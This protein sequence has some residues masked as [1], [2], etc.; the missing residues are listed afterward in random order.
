MNGAEHFQGVTALRIESH[1]VG[2]QLPHSFQ[3]LG[4]A[5]HKGP[6]AF[7][8]FVR[9]VYDNSNC[10]SAQ[11]PN[12][13]HNLLFFAIYFVVCGPGFTVSVLVGD[14]S[15]DAIAPEIG[16]WRA[17][18]KVC[19]PLLGFF[20][21]LF[22]ADNGFFGVKNFTANR[23]LAEVDIGID[24]GNYAAGA[25]NGL[26]H[27]FDALFQA[28]LDLLAMLKLGAG[29]SGKIVFLRLVKH[30]A[31]IVCNRNMVFV[32]PFN[33]HDHHVEDGIDFL[34]VGLLVWTVELEHNRS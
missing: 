21:A 28:V 25:E 7:G 10:Q 18:F 19:T 33:S 6:R 5:G 1:S 4:L 14:G 27:F 12:V 3:F 9:P 20:A 2:N 30:L 13:G 23:F 31:A 16:V 29:N 32:Q 15:G 8:L 22:A 34:L 11:I 24:L 17:C 26:Q